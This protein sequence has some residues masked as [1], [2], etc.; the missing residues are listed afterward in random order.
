L[1]E[2]NKVLDEFSRQVSPEIIGEE[3]KREE[4]KLMDEIVGISN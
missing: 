3:S 1:D 2:E 4:E